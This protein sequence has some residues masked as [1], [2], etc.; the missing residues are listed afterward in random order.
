V[1]REKPNGQQEAHHLTPYPH[2]HLKLLTINTSAASSFI[3]LCSLLHFILA[4][5]GWTERG[6][7]Y[8]MLTEYNMYSATH[9][10][11]KFWILICSRL[12]L[13]ALDTDPDPYWECGSGSGYRSMEIGQN[14]QINLV[15]CLWYLPIVQHMS[16]IAWPV[17]GSARIRIGVAPWI[18]IRIRNRMEIKSG[19]GSGQKAML[20]Q[21]FKE[22]RSFTTRLYLSLHTPHPYKARWISSI[23]GYLTLIHKHL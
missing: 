5:S 21:G 1:F 11:A 17:S 10:Q 18:W 14:L 15:T 22:A 23:L 4:L 9:S 16:F 20:I 7:I 6:I 2:T 13:A 12:H 3:R 19:S 8:L